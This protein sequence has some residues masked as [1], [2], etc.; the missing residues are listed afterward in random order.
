V[1]SL[2]ALTFGNC[3]ILFGRA[4]D[5]LGRRRVFLGGLALF[6]A[7]SLVCGL[8]SSPGVLLAGRALPGLAAAMVSPAALSL[9]TGLFVEEHA[10]NRARTRSSR[11]TCSP[12]AR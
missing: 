5:L 1:L 7:A 11:S 9:L 12:R 8:A 2:Y 6:T 4:G 10:G 3:L